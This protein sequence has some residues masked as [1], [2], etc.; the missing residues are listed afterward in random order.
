MKTKT[1]QFR[2]REY[3]IAHLDTY[4][5]H[6]SW[7]TF[8]IDETGIRDLVWNIEEGDGVLDIGAA[9]GSYSLT[10][11]ASG[12][13][14]VYAWS[15][16]DEDALSTSGQAPGVQDRD[17]FKESLRL[18]GWQDKCHIYSS[19]MYSKP[20]WI[21]TV[22]QQFSDTTVLH[23]DWIQ[24]GTLDGWI[25]IQPEISAV[26]KT[27]KKLWMKLD[28][29]GAEVHVLRG[30][31][32]FIRE[33]K[34]RILVENHQFKDQSTEQQV[35]DLILGTGLYAERFNAKYHSVSHSFYEPL[36]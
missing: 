25:R 12:A 36:G 34:P 1:L 11:L 4:P 30:G 21:N 14:K 5:N 3:Q 35:R 32:E 20:G 23:P 29:E 19:G 15:P 10:A 13:A 27:C 18:N 7:Y 2:G 16:Q 17:V 24:V 26:L 8:D 33:F 9:Y 28:V 22:T 6:P 31:E